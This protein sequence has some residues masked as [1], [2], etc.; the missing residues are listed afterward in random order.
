MT[1]K[2]AKAIQE[3]FVVSLDAIC[4]GQT[5]Y[6]EFDTL[7]HSVGQGVYE[8]KVNG[9]PAYRCVYIAKLEDAV[10]VL[11]CFTKTTNQV[12]KKAMKTAKKRLKDIR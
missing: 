11:H 9:K 3:L 10:H 2:Y 6:L 8:L 7:T 12:D 5:P 1:P 4:K